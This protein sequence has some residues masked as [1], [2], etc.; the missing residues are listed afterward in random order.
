M[1]TT[2]THPPTISGL[3][4]RPGRVIAAAGG[5]AAAIGCVIALAAGAGSQDASITPAG[6][7]QG[8]PAVRPGSDPATLHHHWLNTAEPPAS[9]R[10]R[11][12]ADRFHH[13]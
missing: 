11:R 6:A 7:G 12:Q 9:A 3:R 4:S 13:R 1:S 2:T 5:L 8:T 10:I